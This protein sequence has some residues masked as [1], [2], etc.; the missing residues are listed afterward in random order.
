VKLNQE[1]LVIAAIIAVI[2]FMVG[3]ATSEPAGPRSYADCILDAAR[4][5]AVDN[6]Y[7]AAIHLA[8]AS[9]FGW[10]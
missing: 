3:R 5:G 9:K 2:G 8:C 10:P 7:S 6:K 4:H 1:T